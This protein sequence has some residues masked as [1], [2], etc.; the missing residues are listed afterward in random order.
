MKRNHYCMCSTV[1]L[2]PAQLYYSVTI[3]A[4]KSVAYI[5]ATA[6][7]QGKERMGVV[8]EWPFRLEVNVAEPLNSFYFW[9]GTWFNFGIE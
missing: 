1:P 9:S 3:V 4:F 8:D 6:T 5:S 2:Q 7:G